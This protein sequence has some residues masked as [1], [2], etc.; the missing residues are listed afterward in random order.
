MVILQSWDKGRANLHHHS[1]NTIYEFGIYSHYPLSSTYC[2]LSNVTLTIIHCNKCPMHIFGIYM[3]INHYPVK[4]EC[5]LFKKTWVICLSMMNHYPLLKRSWRTSNFN[6]FIYL[7]QIPF[8]DLLKFANCKIT[9]QIVTGKTSNWIGHQFHN[10]LLPHF[11][12]LTGPS[13]IYI[14]RP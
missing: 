13:S 4:Q 2:S 7:T 5:K 11:T 14:Y 6:A 12:A 9:I 10:K 8:G 3:L 1:P